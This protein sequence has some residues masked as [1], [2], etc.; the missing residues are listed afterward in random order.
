SIK[1]NAHHRAGEQMV[2]HS[3][4]N[5]S[6]IMVV[7]DEVGFAGGFNIGDDY[8]RLWRDTHVRERGP[9]VWALGQSSLHQVER[10]PPRGR[11]DG[12]AQ[13]VQPLEDH[14][15]GRRGR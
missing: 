2:R 9:A 10:P 3:G 11:A 12:P 13:R 14:G 15:G 4:F 7:D 5:H 6:K 1:W 8:A